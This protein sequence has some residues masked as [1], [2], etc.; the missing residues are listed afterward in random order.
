[1]RMTLRVGESRAGRAALGSV[2]ATAAEHS[3]TVLGREVAEVVAAERVAVPHVEG[4]A[5]RDRSTASPARGI[6]PEAML[7][8]YALADDASVAAIGRCVVTCGH[9]SSAIW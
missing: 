4:H 9:R 6:L 5:G 3:A 7:T 8:L 2:A 1:M